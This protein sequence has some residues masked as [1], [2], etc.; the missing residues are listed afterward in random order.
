[1]TKSWQMAMFLQ[2]ACLRCR[3]ATID[4]HFSNLLHIEMSFSTG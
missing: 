4:A 2:E 3:H 1:V